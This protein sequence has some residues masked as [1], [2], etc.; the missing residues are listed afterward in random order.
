MHFI[1]WIYFSA[2]AANFDF[3]I[4]IPKMFET[5][6]KTSM[7]DNV[8]LT[9]RSLMYWAKT[10]AKE[11]YKLIRES[12]LDYFLEQTIDSPLSA[13]TSDD[14]KPTGCGEADLVEV[15]YHMKK[16]EYCCVNVRDNIWYQYKNH[17]WFQIDS[18]TT[19]RSSISTDLRKEYLKKAEDLF[20]KINELPEGD[21]RLEPMRK[22][23]D[24]I[25]AIVNRLGKTGDKKNMMTEAKD[26]FYDGEFFKRLDMNPYLLC[27]RNGVWDFKEKI[28]RAGRPD[29]YIAMS[30]NID[31][32]PINAVQDV[33]T[34]KEVKLFMQQLFPEPELER[35][36]WEHLAS[37]L[38]GVALDQTFNNYIGGGSNGKS[39]LTNLM[40]KVLGDYKYDLPHTAITS[41]ER[42]KVGGV[43]PEIAS[44]KGKR[45]VVMAEPSKGD[46]I[47]EG[48]MKQFT[49]GNDK[50]TARGLYMIE[51][52]EFLPQFKLVVCANQLLKIN[53]TDHGTWRRIR[54]VDFKS[55]FTPNPVDT[56]P[57]K[58]YQYKLVPDIEKKF[59]GKFMHVFMA[60]LIEI[61]LQ[62][63]GKV[64]DCS[65][66]M[67]SS[68]RY[69]QSQDVI[70]EF[71]NDYYVAC[72]GAKII[73]KRDVSKD[74]EEWHKDTY[75]SKGPQ[76]KDVYE[77]MDKKYGKN[78]KNTWLNITK[79]LFVSEDDID[80]ENPTNEIM[81]D[82]DFE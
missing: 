73:K 72:P 13:F 46:V 79:R 70:A 68:D 74:F 44:L 18:G 30:T 27:F 32:V 26:R 52:L 80:G 50:I 51:A 76:P 11:K 71:I 38:I 57:L 22:R 3:G 28:F 33:D 23:L 40:G 1:I 75:G 21:N 56:D 62:T 45:Y 14:K 24:R 49:A 9:K 31:Y 17:R 6:D 34:V 2:Q 37:T 48:I 81:E 63:Q 4:E 53:T 5:W 8:G 78:V 29:D 15:L 36:M 77:Y 58:P 55:L 66:V 82:V 10:D 7:V 60:L 20:L 59:E 12:T 65:I 69:R 35:Y 54:L 41:K 19:L 43:S 16:D 64:N 25:M 47:N 42:T 67:S 61:A 39:V